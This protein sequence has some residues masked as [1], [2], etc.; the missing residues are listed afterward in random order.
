MGE[1]SGDSRAASVVNA[2]K[3]KEGYA[4][5]IRVAGKRELEVRR[6]ESRQRGLEPLRKLSRPLPPRV[7]L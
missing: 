1:Q 2:L 7:R 6:E 4:I 5:E 3:L